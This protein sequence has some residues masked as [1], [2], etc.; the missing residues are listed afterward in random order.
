MR[1]VPESTETL[2]VV[3]STAPPRANEGG[4]TSG[5]FKLHVGEAPPPPQPSSKQ[6]DPQEGRLRGGDIR[7]VAGGKVLMRLR[8]DLGGFSGGG[9]RA[10]EGTDEALTAQTYPEAISLS[11][12]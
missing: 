12:S 10:P 9:G 2:A 3:G 8:G 5:S 1:D 4:T 6:K 11:D 7:S